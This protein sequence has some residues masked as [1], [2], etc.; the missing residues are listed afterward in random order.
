MDS[1]LSLVVRNSAT[2]SSINNYVIAA[3]NIDAE[4]ISGTSDFTSTDPW[5]IFIF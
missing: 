1:S 5:E 4:R 3:G 2:G